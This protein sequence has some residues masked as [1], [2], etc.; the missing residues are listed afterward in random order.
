MIVA[1][2]H[3]YTRSNIS[4]V[5][6]GQS[7]ERFNFSFSDDRSKP[8]IYSLIN[9]RKRLWELEVVKCVS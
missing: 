2:K 9:S 3:K 1:Y 8:V 4:V 5:G 7:V 6:M